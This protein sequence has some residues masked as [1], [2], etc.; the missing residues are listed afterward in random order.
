MNAQISQKTNDITSQLTYR[1]W[2]IKQLDES[3]N[4]SIYGFT[5][6]ITSFEFQETPL[7]ILVQLIIS[8]NPAWVFLQP[9]PWEMCKIIP[10][11]ETF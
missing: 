1:N 8:Q 6:T 11:F 10:F 5:G 7:S 9:N 3:C 2:N 4:I